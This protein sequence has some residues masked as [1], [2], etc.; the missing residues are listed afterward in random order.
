MTDIER[1]LVRLTICKKVRPRSYAALA[2]S[3]GRTADRGSEPRARPRDSDLAQS[4]Q[5]LLSMRTRGFH[6]ARV[7]RR[8]QV[9]GNAPLRVRRAARRC[10]HLRS[11][12]CAARRRTR[13]HE[14]PRLPLWLRP[15][16]DVDPTGAARTIAVTCDGCT[17]SSSGGFPFSSSARRAIAKPNPE[18]W[19]KPSTRIA[20]AR[21]GLR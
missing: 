12:S 9:K 6:C 18:R 15:A 17:F 13:R 3:V 8:E 11:T 2:F 21:L 7:E 20:S 16:Y 19:T 5:K 10:R 1:E 4:I 14:H